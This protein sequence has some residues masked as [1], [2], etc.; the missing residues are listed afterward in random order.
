MAPSFSMT[1]CRCNV[2]YRLHMA[3]WQTRSFSG[4]VREN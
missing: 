1:C 3:G 2:G 4:V